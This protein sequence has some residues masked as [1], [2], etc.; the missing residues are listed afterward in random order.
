[1][2]Y[3]SKTNHSIPKKITS[4]LIDSYLKGSKSFLHHKKT[5]TKVQH[6]NIFDTREKIHDTFSN[7]V[8][9]ARTL[10]SRFQEQVKNENTREQNQMRR[11]ISNNSFLNANNNSSFSL[12]APETILKICEHSK[13]KSLHS[14]LIQDSCTVSELIKHKSEISDK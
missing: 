9:S 12:H 3:S 14:S 10:N 1:M 5:E 4:D 13:K 8:N 6:Q 7:R 11:S 2:K